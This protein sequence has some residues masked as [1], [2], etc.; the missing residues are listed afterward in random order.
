MR[1][2][3]VMLVMSGCASGETLAPGAGD[4][5]QQTVSGSDGGGHVNSSDDA[6]EHVYTQEVQPHGRA[7]GHPLEMEGDAGPQDGGPCPACPHAGMVCVLGECANP[8]RT[9]NECGAGQVCQ[10]HGG[11]EVCQ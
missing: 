11:V 1:A 3:V 2:I 5:E 6:G 10:V 9:S 4:A 7:Q 8:C